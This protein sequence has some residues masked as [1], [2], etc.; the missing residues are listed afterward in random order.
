MEVVS[1]PETLVRF[2]NMNTTVNKIQKNTYHFRNSAI[3]NKDHMEKASYN[4][5]AEDPAGFLD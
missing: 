5:E 2:T 1:S 4:K 3:C